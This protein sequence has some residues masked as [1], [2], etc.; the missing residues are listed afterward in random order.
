ME[1][2]LRDNG[3]G[4]KLGEDK[5]TSSVLENKGGSS[6]SVDGTGKL[7]S[8]STTRSSSAEMVSTL[9]N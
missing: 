1:G 8:A 2:P 5:P 6:D 3:V 7:I 4:G 9:Y